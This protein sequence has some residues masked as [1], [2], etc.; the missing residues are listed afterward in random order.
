MPA[1]L[2][3]LKRKWKPAAMVY[4]A[5]SQAT[6]VLA[7]SPKLKRMTTGLDHRTYMQACGA[8]YEALGRA[9]VRHTGQ[10]ELDAAVQACRR[11]KGGSE[12]WSWTR[13]NRSEDI[14]PL[15]ACTLAFHGLTEKDKK[16][17]NQW[18]VL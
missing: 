14:S 3:E 8:F 18:A 6:E 11:S 10:E 9:Q 4:T 7:A 2:E 12:L 5:A 13:D 15:V 17:G 16:G 1:R